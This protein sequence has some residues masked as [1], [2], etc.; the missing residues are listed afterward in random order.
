MAPKAAIA[1]KGSQTSN[2]R[3]TMLQPIAQSTCKNITLYSGFKV[4]A[5]VRKTTS[6][7]TSHNPRFIKKA[8]NSFLVRLIPAR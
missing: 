8:D 3:I 6:T 5:R 2:P 1:G 4:N 7:K